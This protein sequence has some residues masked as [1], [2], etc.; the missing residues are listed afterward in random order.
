VLT[1]PAAQAREVALREPAFRES[2]HLPRQRV[3]A[4]QLLLDTGQGVLARM[5]HGERDQRA[6]RLRMLERK[7]PPGH[8]APV[9]SHDVHR[10]IGRQPTEQCAQVGDDVAQ[11]VST[12]IRGRL[13]ASEAAQVRREHAAASCDQPRR[14]FIPEV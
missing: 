1:A 14:H 11:C 4:F 5:P 13:R 2:G 9:V 7:A 10:L 12:Y 6:H 8:G 3:Q